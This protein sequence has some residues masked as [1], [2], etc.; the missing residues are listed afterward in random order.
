M[1]TRIVVYVY[2]GGSGVDISVA[3]G[4]KEKHEKGYIFHFISWYW[5]GRARETRKPSLSRGRPLS[6]IITALNDPTK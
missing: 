4:D 5:W 1:A 3:R 6:P 2:F